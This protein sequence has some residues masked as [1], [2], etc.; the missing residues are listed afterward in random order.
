M[1]PRKQLQQQMYTQLHQQHPLVHVTQPCTAID[2]LP[3]GDNLCNGSLTNTETPKTTTT[4]E[5]TTTL[6]TPIG[7]GHAAMHSNRYTPSW[8]QFM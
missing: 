2:T 4:N 6:T 7:T 5:C 3:V 1:R 8:R